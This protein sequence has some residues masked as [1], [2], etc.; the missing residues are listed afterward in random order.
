VARRV[1]SGDPQYFGVGVDDRADLIAADV[2]HEYA[3]LPTNLHRG[4]RNSAAVLRFRCGFGDRRKLQPVGLKCGAHLGDSMGYFADGYGTAVYDIYFDS[5]QGCAE[6]LVEACGASLGPGADILDVGAG[7]G[8]VSIEAARRFGDSRIIGVDID[9]E[10]LDLARHK[11]AEFSLNNVKF[12]SGNALDLPHADNSF[13]AVMANQMVGDSAAQVKMLSEMLRVVRPGGGVGV[14]RSNPDVN[15]VMQWIHDVAVKISDR[16]GIEPPAIEENPWSNRLSARRMLQQFG[17]RGI[18]ADRFISAQT[19]FS[20]FLINLMTQGRNLLSLV[21]Y[22]TQ[23]DLDDPAAQSRGCWEF[24]QVGREL[25]DRKY[26]GTLDIACEVVSGTKVEQ[27]MPA[28]TADRQA[29]EAITPPL[30]T[31][32]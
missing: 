14:A 15:E 29:R 23:C 22:V 27:P 12:E 16:R 5:A 10:A 30:L 26:G 31:S 7:T 6:R 20:T 32:L 17:V 11:A 21:E 18:R 3:P 2:D 1:I 4:H 19:D 25:M 13:D 9:E 24:L 8:N 28:A